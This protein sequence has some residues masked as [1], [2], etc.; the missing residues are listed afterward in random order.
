MNDLLRILR[1]RGLTAGALE[2][3]PEHLAEI[4]T[5]VESKQVTTNTGKELLEKA[6]DSGDSP[7][8]IVEAEGLMQVSDDSAIRQIAQ[9]ILD[10][11]PDQVETY[12]GGKD[13]LIGWFVGQVMKASQGKA[14]P[15]MAK[16]I[17]EQLLQE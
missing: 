12:K 2:L 4:V 5:M 7:A 14:N 11:N 16:E 8:K 17:L 15:Q 6:A 10:Q 9:E 3:T 1:E 13:T